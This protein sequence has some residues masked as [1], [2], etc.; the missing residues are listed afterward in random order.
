MPGSF[1]HEFYYSPH[2]QPLPP[3]PPMTLLMTPPPSH[4]REKQREIVTICGLVTVIII[5][6]IFM[7]WGGR[8]REGVAG[9]RDVESG[10]GVAGQEQASS[11]SA[12]WVLP[13]ISVRRISEP[14]CAVCL[15]AFEEGNECLVIPACSHVYHKS[16]ID[17]W[18]A[19]NRQ[20][21]LCRASVNGV[22]QVD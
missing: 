2:S 1:I 3:P 22:K 9:N 14:E 7:L 19:N 15:E 17:Q 20:C 8:R 6:S 16:C 4:N 21:P 10:R 5:C 11:V 13:A 12:S 18:L